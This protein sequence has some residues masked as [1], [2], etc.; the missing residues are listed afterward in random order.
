MRDSERG[1]VRQTLESM[2]P[3]YREYESEEDRRLTQ[4]LIWA[5][6]GVIYRQASAA[7]WDLNPFDDV[8]GLTSM[9]RRK[10]WHMDS[11]ESTF[12]QRACMRDETDWMWWYNIVGEGPLD[13]TVKDALYRYDLQI[14]R[15]GEEAKHTIETCLE[16]SETDPLRRMRAIIRSVD[17]VESVLSGRDSL[18]ESLP[19]VQTFWARRSEARR[20]RQERRR[21]TLVALAGSSTVI[22]LLLGIVFG[23]GS[24]RTKVMAPSTRSQLGNASSANPVRILLSLAGFTIAFGFSSYF[25]RE[26]FP[27]PKGS[28]ISNALS[29]STAL[30]LSAL[31]SLWLLTAE[32]AEALITRIT[33]GFVGVITT[34]LSVLFVAIGVYL[35]WKRIKSYIKPK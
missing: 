15:R 12:T 13:R 9:L 35:A 22:A 21:K 2:I 29:F 4:R 23:V 24:I 27:W 17:K 3:G 33:Q 30:F 6:L 1:N 8:W 14:V 26:I 20:L 25:L 5:Y 34:T 7:L 32:A 31:L 11:E 19:A 10:T 18:L 28:R 16:D